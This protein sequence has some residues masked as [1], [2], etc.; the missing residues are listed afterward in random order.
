M[1]AMLGMYDMAPLQP[2]ND[3]FWAAIRARLGDGPAHLTRDRAFMEIWQDPR[4]VL[5][6]TCGMPY[7]TRLH[8]A[9]QLVGTPDYGLQDC[10]PGYYNSVLVV[11]AEDP[12][13]DLAA[14]DGAC[15]AYNDALSQSGWA[16]VIT[17]L[18]GLGLAPGST[19]ATGAHALSARAVA[20]GRADLAGIDA[21]TWALLC[22]HTP[23]VTSRLRALA[24][25]VPTPALPYVTGPGRD[26]AVVAAAMAGAMDDLGAEDRAALHLRGLVSVPAQDYLAVPTPPAPGMLTPETA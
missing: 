17:H 21:L 20:E 23:E 1:V 25:T 14:Y 13:A 9:V 5:A 16:A 12:R 24:R 26:A 11:R 8:G 19:L 3:R 10:P 15:L 4:L 7:R 6:Q 2:A 22:R 18:S